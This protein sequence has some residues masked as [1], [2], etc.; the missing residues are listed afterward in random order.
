MRNTKTRDTVVRCETRYID[1]DCY[2]Y[3][4]IVN[5]SR[6]T[7][8]YRIMLYSVEIEFSGADGTKTQGEIRDAFADPGRAVLFFDKL[9]NNLATP[10]DLPYVLEDSMK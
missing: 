7:S 6:S 3:R 9:V 8:S 2:I 4:L 1:G 5:E 10:I